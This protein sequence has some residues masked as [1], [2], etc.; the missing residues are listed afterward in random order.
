LDLQTNSHDHA[1]I[2]PLDAMFSNADEVDEVTKA[3]KR[4]AGLTGYDIK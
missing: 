2:Y 3:N 4:Y 1:Q